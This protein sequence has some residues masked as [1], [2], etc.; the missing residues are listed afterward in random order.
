MVCQHAVLHSFP[1]VL[2]A[3]PGRRRCC[4]CCPPAV[5]AL[6]LLC[7]LGLLLR[8][9]Q[10]RPEDKGVEGG[11]NGSLLA[12]REQGLLLVEVVVIS[13]HEVMIVHP[14]HAWQKMSCIPYTTTCTT[15]S[16]PGGWESRAGKPQP[17][18][19]TV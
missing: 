8:S 19:V 14:A 18:G 10:V 9:R 4:S 2:P 1:T 15:G 11:C 5:L 13:H 12:Q 6:R 16:G 3:S 7:T 17:A